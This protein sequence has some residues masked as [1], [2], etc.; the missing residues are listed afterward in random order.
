MRHG[1]R[2]WVR[3]RPAIFVKEWGDGAVVRYDHKPGAPRVV[4]L[5][6]IERSPTGRLRGDRAA[7]VER[8][9]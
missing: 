9:R 8:L 6:S 3:Q 4:P 2:V 5:T 7:A 1:E